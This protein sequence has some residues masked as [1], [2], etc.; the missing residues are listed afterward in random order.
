M[1]KSHTTAQVR[2]SNSLTD[3]F[4]TNVGLNKARRWAGTS[5]EQVRGNL[6]VDTKDTLLYKSC[7]I[8]AYADDIN[9]MARTFTLAKETFYKPR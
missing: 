1:I 6:P 5:T 8:V 2:V 9:I 3:T 4:T 7:Q